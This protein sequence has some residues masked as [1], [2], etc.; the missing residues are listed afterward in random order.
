MKRRIFRLWI[1]RLC[2]FYP[3]FN[4]WHDLKNG[5]LP[6]HIILHEYYAFY[7]SAKQPDSSENS[8]ASEPLKW[9]GRRALPPLARRWQLAGPEGCVAE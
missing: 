2:Q 4:I 8:P 7:L 6:P 1:P 9:G 3:Y 5:F